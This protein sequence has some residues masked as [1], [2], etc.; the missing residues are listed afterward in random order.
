MKPLHALG[1]FLRL[2]IVTSGILLVVPPSVCAQNI[3][4]IPVIGFLAVDPPP[5]HG[6]GFSE[7]FRKSMEDIGYVEGK[8]IR[9]EWRFASGRTELLPAMAQELIGLKVDLIVTDA[10][11]STV[12]ATRATA[13]IPI[14]FAAAVEPITA[15]IIDTYGH[16]GGNVTGFALI[17]SDLAGK[18]LE[19]LK[20]TF[21]KVNRVGI[22][23]SPRNPGHYPALK[24]L[25]LAARKL[26]MST[27][28]FSVESPAGFEPAFTEMRNWRAD[29]LL[30]L[31]EAF[32]DFHRKLIAEL[33]IKG[34]LPSIFGYRLFVEGGGLM[35]YGP[36]LA[37]QFRRCTKI[38]DKV[39]K[40]TRPGDIPIEQPA[41]FEMVINLKTMNALKITIPE[42]IRARADLL[43]H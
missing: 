8:T 7:V 12:A 20:E 41:K 21:P 35:S 19:L 16:P 5:P 40:G 27:R 43:I 29:A 6:P 22:L 15:G 1:E 32:L 3:E 33:A 2:V 34:R 26:R 37:D 28:G 14:V 9:I 31:D 42:P 11:A 23:W 24:E 36:D 18:R 38:V 4:K 39:L 25:E 10:T 30:V 13:V 17:L